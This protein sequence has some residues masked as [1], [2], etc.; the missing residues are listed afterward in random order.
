[1]IPSPAMK[2]RA[3]HIANIEA[4][5]QMIET[6]PDES[7][8]VGKSKPELEALLDDFQEKLDVDPALQAPP[9]AKE[10]FDNYMELEKMRKATILG[11]A[12]AL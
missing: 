9:D 5:R 7:P 6:A 4:I 1:M 3:E 10:Q 2:A 12:A 8:E 11:A